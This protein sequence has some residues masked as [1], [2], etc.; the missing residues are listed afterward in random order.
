MHRRLIERI[1]L[2]ALLAS[3]AFLLLFRMGAIG[4]TWDEGGDLTTVQCLEDT[5]DPFACTDDISQTR[6]PFYIHALAGSLMP[7]TRP[8][9]LVSFV[10]SALTLACIYLFALRRFGAG[11]AALAGALYVTSPQLLASGRMVVSHSNIICTFF[12]TVAFLAVVKLTETRRLRWL[13]VC[14]L[15]CGAAAACSVVAIFNAP[16]LLAIYL[17]GRRA[18][19]KDLLFFPIAAATF[20]ATTIVYVQPALFRG[21]IAACREPNFYKFWNYLGMGPYAPWYFP[22]VILIVKAGTWWLLLAAL[23]GRNV[24]RWLVAF[25]A[26]FLGTLVL[27]GALFHYDAPHHQV[28]FYPLLYLLIAVALGD[29][30]RRRPRV[31]G[32]AIAAAFVVQLYGVVQFFPN[33]LF[34]GAQ[35]GDRFIGEFYGPAVIHGQDRDHTWQIIDA[36]LA[37]EPHAQFLVADNNIFERSGASYVPFTQ[38]DPH[39]RYEYALVDRLYAKHFDA[40][41]ER[42][43][44]NAYLA[45]HYTPIDTR[46]WPPHVWMYRVLRLR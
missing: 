46:T 2:A 18:S 30:V 45:E 44:F 20:F 8:H 19:W 10:F 33:Y 4:F 9:F 21:L 15:A 1:A 36:I 23:F 35:Y 24:P 32:I 6:L 5:H 29:A 7:G 3:L 22:L 39:A 28:Q 38:R 25:G 12:T 13:V 42:D 41:P 11:I 31:A 37:R 34:Y 26:A 16:A 17:A 40:F 27:K 43:A 14:A